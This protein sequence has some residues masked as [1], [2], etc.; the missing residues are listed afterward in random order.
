MNMEYLMKKWKRIIDGNENIYIFGNG[1]VGGRLLDLIKERGAESKFKGFIVSDRKKY[2]GVDEKHRV[3]GL[4][5]IGDKDSLVL[6]SVSDIYHKEVYDS[7][8]KSGFSNYI[9]SIE[10]FM[11]EDKNNKSVSETELN[12]LFDD[13]HKIGKSESAVR[14]RII[15]FFAESNL[16]FDEDRPY[17]SFPRLGIRGQRNTLK[18]L[19]KYH[20]FDYMGDKSDVFDIGCNYGFLDME[21]AGRVNSI[22]GLEYSAEM[23][24]LA[25]DISQMLG[26]EN[27]TF[28]SGDYNE[29]QK[30][31]QDGSFDAIFSFAVHIWLNISA[32]EYTDQIKRMLRDGGYVFFESQTYGSDALFP[33]FCETFLKKGFQVKY[34]NMLC[35]DGE[36]ERKIIVF[37]KNA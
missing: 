1:V 25:S 19:E 21:I 6:V 23:V 12:E 11:L 13:N 16:P 24:E 35:D 28:R 4:N 18:R 29:Y 10:F 2:K 30:N 32:E 8:E 27:L 3:F 20:L 22:L 26:I 31:I 36:I 9:N 15:R 33:I 17:Q 34:E 5:E 7:L 14:D 37:Q